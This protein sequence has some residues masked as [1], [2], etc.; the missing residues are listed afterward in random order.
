[1]K[2]LKIFGATVNIH[3]KTRKTEFKEKYLKCILAGF[4]PNLYKVWDVESEKC[5]V[6][7]DFIFDETNFLE[8]RPGIKAEVNSGKSHFS[9]EDLTDYDKT[10]PLFA[11][12]S[13][14]RFIMASSNQFDLLVDYMDVKT[15]FSHYYIE[16]RN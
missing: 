5:N 3:N 7:W 8:S 16:R 15:N 1:M 13:S 2:H 4:E 9:Q 12:I 11:G 10:F 6:I 14:F